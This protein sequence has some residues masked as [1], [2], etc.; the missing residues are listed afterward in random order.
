[1]A[2][3]AIWKGYINFGDVNLPVKLHTAIREDRIQFHLL[4]RRD[5][6]KLHQQMICAYENE[7]VPAEAQVKGFEVE[8]GKYII[9]DP[10]ELE[11]ANPESSRLVE[12]H[13]FVKSGEIDFLFLERVYYLE[14][15]LNVQGYNTL[16]S[17]L[18]EMDVAGICT[19]AMR[20]KNYLGALQASGKILRLTT[21]RHADEVISARSLELESISLSEKELK[22]GDELINQLT[23]PFQP[24]KFENEHQKKLQLLIDKKARGEKIAV[25][26]PRQLK[27]TSSDKLLQ[28]LEA[29]LKRVA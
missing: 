5:R 14:P 12:V 25:L 7:P 26:R 3:K 17:T 1:M 10:A 2:G 22:I 11:Q 8:D 19:W 28:A 9:V 21:L 23:V 20:K 13:D 18:K 6:V 29:S 15:D 16:V 24:H 4:H 27:P